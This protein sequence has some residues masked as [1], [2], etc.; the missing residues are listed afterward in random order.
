MLILT[1]RYQ[2]VKHSSI[3]SCSVKLKTEWYGKNNKKL[4]IYEGNWIK[5]SATRLNTK[6]FITAKFKLNITTFGG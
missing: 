2:Y 1:K 6:D 3:K 5:E 4:T